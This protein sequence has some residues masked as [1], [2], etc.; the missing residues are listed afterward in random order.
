GHRYAPA[1][2]LEP[3]PLLGA[4]LPEWM[5]L[6]F[7]TSTESGW[8]SP[9]VL[10]RTYQRKLTQNGITFANV[11]NGRGQL[12]DELSSSATCQTLLGQVHS[13]ELQLAAIAV[14]A[15]LD[16]ALV[17]APGSKD[18]ESKA[19]PTAQ[20]QAPGPV[21]AVPQPQGGYGLNFPPNFQMPPGQQ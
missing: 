20:T 6:H 8:G 21:T 15:N 13:Q 14:E 12:L 17:V 3:S 10:S 9:Q 19:E 18:K 7:Q 16:N 5:L 1:I 11:T 4:D 2:V